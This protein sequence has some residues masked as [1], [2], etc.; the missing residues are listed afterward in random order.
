MKAARGVYACFKDL[1]DDF[2]RMCHNALVYNKPETYYHSAALEMLHLGNAALE[3]FASRAARS[4]DLTTGALLPEDVTPPLSIALTD[5]YHI[6]PEGEEG[7]REMYQQMLAARQLPSQS[8]RTVHFRRLGTRLHE[9]QAAREA[10]KRKRPSSPPRRQKQK[11][12]EPP[13]RPAYFHGDLVWAKYSKYYW[14]PALV[15]DPSSPFPPP[16]PAYVP[17]QAVLDLRP[18]HSDT[19]ANAC[20][21][22]LFFDKQRNWAWVASSRL[23]TLLEDVDADAALMSAAPSSER[24]GVK[25]AYEMAEVFQRRQRAQRHAVRM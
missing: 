17:P 25:D 19:S 18:R 14:Y 12:L 21:L 2:Q 3:A 23:R 9:L 7:E 8:A 6:D 4:I 15:V 11:A 22:V 1:V 5:I 20:M 24:K 16:D 13:Q 10:R